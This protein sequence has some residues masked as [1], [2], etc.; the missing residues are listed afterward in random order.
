ME[1]EHPGPRRERNQRPSASARPSARIRTSSSW[2]KLVDFRT[3]SGIRSLYIWRLRSM[4]SWIPS[5]QEGRSCTIAG[6]SATV[7]GGRMKIAVVAPSCPLKREAAE[8]V[9]VNGSDE[10]LRVAMARQ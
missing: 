9:Q 2:K 5:P 7:I 6:A 8:A 1:N 10:L 3:S 4:S